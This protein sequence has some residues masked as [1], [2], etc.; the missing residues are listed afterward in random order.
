MCIRDSGTT[1]GQVGRIT[2]N[3]S[4]NNHGVS[5]QSPAH[6]AAASYTLTL[7]ED[8]GSANQAL[9]TDGNGV[10]SWADSGSPTIDAGNFDTG[11]SATIFV[12]NP[13]TGT[14]PTR[15]CLPT[16]YAESSVIDFVKSL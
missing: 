9:T 4:N 8:T 2:L 3:C 16:Y 10:L 6:S 7:P 5:I 12:S 13:T 11:G 15:T 14:I 1:N